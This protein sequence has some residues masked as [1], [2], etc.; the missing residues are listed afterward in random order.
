MSWE[1][2]ADWD[3]GAT[4]STR[5]NLKIMDRH[6]VYIFLHDAGRFRRIGKLVL[7]QNLSLRFKWIRV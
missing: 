5:L 4:L 3:S 2:A 1:V 7:A 6:G